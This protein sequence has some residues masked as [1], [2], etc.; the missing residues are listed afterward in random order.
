MIGRYWGFSRFI[1]DVYTN[2]LSTSQ[3]V[4]LWFSFQ[5]FHGDAKRGVCSGA[6]RVI[7]CLLPLCGP[8]VTSAGGQDPWT[9]LSSSPA[10]TSYSRDGYSS[11]HWLASHFGGFTRDRPLGTQN[12]TVLLAQ[13]PP[14]N[15]LPFFHVASFLSYSRES[16]PMLLL[17][18]GSVY[19]SQDC[20]LSALSFLG[21]DTASPHTVT[22]SSR[23]L[24]SFV[25]QWLLSLE[26]GHVSCGS[27]S[28]LL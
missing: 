17:K 16:R 27:L 9:V 28:T 19:L 13:E 8:S 23:Y 12:S 26:L 2:E 20:P 4:A 10:S 14:Y 18:H 24:A 5:T 6:V 3:Q 15:S 11:V 1:D 25:S 22:V 21:C 7:S